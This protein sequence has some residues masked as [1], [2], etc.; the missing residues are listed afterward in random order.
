A[1]M[2]IPISVSASRSDVPRDQVPNATAVVDRATI[3]RG[4][5]TI[6]LDESLALVPGV[7]AVNRYN[8]SLDQ[9]ISIRGFGARSAFAVRGITVLLDGIPQTLPDG[10]GQLTN[11]ELGET[12]RIEVLRGSASALYGNA[13]GG[14]ISIWS[15]P[16]PPSR[17]TEEV[18]MTGGTSGDGLQHT[19]NKWLST[20]RWRVGQ[21]LALVTASRLVYDGERQHSTADLRT[22]N[23]RLV[24]P[25]GD[26]WTMSGIFDVGDDP[27]ADNPG[28]LTAAEL[29]ANPESAGAIYQSTQAGKRVRQLQGGLTVR[30]D[31]AGGGQ[32][33]LTAFGLGRS[34]ENP[35]TY[36]FIDLARRAY[37]VRGSMSRPA[38]LVGVHQTLTAGFDTQWQRDDRANFANN[39]GASGAVPSLNQLEHVSSVGPFVQTAIALAP[40]VTATVGARYDRI[41]FR[42]HDRLVTATNPDDS[43]DRLMHALSGSAGV[44]WHV[45]DAATVYANVGSSFETPTTTEL[46]NRPDTAGGFNP[47][48][49]PLTATTYEL[50]VRGGVAGRLTYSVALYEAAVRDELIAFE[51]PSSPGRS[52]Y[53]NA[54]RSRHRGVELGATATLAPGYSLAAN[55]TVSDFRYV[56]YDVSDR[57]LDGRPLPGIP[58]QWVDVVLHS[59]P[60]SGPT[61]IDLEVQHA[62]GYLVDDTLTA[63][64]SPWT[65]LGVRLGW[66][67]SAGGVPVAPFVAVN[68]LFDRR[69][70][71]S[72]VINAAGGRYFEPAPGRNVYLG[73]SIAVGS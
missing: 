62:S 27:R 69:Y 64:T 21:G 54:G 48:L 67:G 6:G 32:A 14:V 50:G 37:G 65:T 34:L 5:P 66:Q 73:L 38:M 58:P 10:Q 46:A 42:V 53:R 36:A 28:S 44:T 57:S 8:F 18:R 61:W 19:W 30:R 12:D 56:R 9:R 11:L 68:N 1:A 29:A 15:D 33:S 45:V 3:T 60:G 23:T 26:G 20:T 41:R 25:A 70:V 2:L 4:R 43:G 22:L 49:D 13:A 59:R 31:F 71:S 39:G 52:F 7:Y 47:S 40:G 51:E 55:W 35:Q 24:L 63:R 72:V 17:A 16:V